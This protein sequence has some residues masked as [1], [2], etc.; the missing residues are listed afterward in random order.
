VNADDLG[1]DQ[2]RNAGIF[3]A[4]DAGIVTSVSLFANAPATNDAVKRLLS[5]E[6]RAISIGLHFNIS[7]GEPLSKGL[8]KL[9]ASDGNFLGKKAA[10]LLLSSA[11][12]AELEDE[13]RRE[14]GAQASALLNAGIALDH[15]DGHQHVHV[16]PGALM[17]A[18]EETKN[19]GIPWFRIPLEQPNPS[20]VLQPGLLQETDTFNKHAEY[21]LTRTRSSGL[22][23]TDHFRGLYYKGNLPADNW[24]GFL[25]AI[26]EG[27]TELMVH[28]G[29]AAVN[30]TGNPFSRFST[31]ER[32]LEFHALVDGRFRSAL[33]AAEIELVSFPGTVI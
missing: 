8:K 9:I 3:E 12:D 2:A 15:S 26:P 4:I 17:V 6:S 27:L 13:I 31:A 22:R 18:L 30:P 19:R 14:F 23:A 1:A 20:W 24:P 16:F 28:P 7:E 21:A 33:L 11:G 32:E 10:H 5:I 25:A 29:R